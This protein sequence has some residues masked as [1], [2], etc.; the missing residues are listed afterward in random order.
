[1]IVL[2]CLRGEIPIPADMHRRRSMARR[3]ASNGSFKKRQS[4]CHGTGHFCLSTTAPEPT[5][6]AWNGGV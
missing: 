3:A 2:E 5:F 1:M 4:I 6:A